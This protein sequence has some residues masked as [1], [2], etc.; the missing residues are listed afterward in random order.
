MQ[1]YIDSYIKNNRKS[2]SF[3]TNNDNE[4]KNI[5]STLKSFESPKSIYKNR[6]EI[7]IRQ[8]FIFYIK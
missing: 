3:F 1:N 5:K 2:I 7:K 4:N 6:S 8:D